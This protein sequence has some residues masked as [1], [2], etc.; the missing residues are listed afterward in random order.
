MI[1][2][3]VVST[4]YKRRN[5]VIS[6]NMPMWSKSSAKICEKFKTVT[7]VLTEKLFY[8]FSHVIFTLSVVTIKPSLKELFS[9]N[10]NESFEGKGYEKLT[11]HE[12]SEDNA[13]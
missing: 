5:V 1:F 4:S 12:Y 10:Y 11:K 9:K 7:A 6:K 13:E 3:T 8:F 2:C